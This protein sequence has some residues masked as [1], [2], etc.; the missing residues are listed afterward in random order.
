MPSLL[1]PDPVT[2][3]QLEIM[4]HIRNSYDNL[5][6]YY[7]QVNKYQTDMEALQKQQDICRNTAAEFK[8]KTETAEK[9]I[10]VLVEKLHL[11]I[12]AKKEVKPDPNQMN[13]ED[14]VPIELGRVE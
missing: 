1:L 12:L 5:V 2:T 11:S 6:Y 9:E 7:G 8:I 4:N 13:I 10:E 3:E 14:L